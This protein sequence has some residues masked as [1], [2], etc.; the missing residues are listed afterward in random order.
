MEMD[1]DAFEQLVDA[2]GYKKRKLMPLETFRERFRAAMAEEGY[3]SREDM[4]A[5]VREIKRE[6]VN[7]E[8]GTMD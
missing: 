5:L 7:E 4:L 8:T 1:N 6:L 2:Q 3:E